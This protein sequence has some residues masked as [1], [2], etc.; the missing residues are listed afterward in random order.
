[1]LTDVRLFDVYRGKGIEDGEKSLAFEVT[2]QPREKTL[3][4]EE[5]E[6]IS[7]RIVAQAGKAG[8]RLR[9]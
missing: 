7:V 2:L 5:I 3:T 4:D 8:G 1:M 9:G 6:A